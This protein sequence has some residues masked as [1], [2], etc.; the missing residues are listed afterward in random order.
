MRHRRGRRRRGGGRRFHRGR[1]RRRP[2]RAGTD[3]DPATLSA[4]PAQMLPAALPRRRADVDARS[5][6]GWRCR[7]GVASVGRRSSTRGPA[8]GLR[9]PYSSV[10][11]ASYGLEGFGKRRTRYGRTSSAWSSA[12][13]VAEVAPPELAGENAA[14]ARRG[15]ERLGWSHGYLRRNAKGCVG[16]GVCAFGCP[17]GAKQHAGITYVPRAA[18][19]RRGRC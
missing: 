10:G 13:S 19:G 15:A 8:S 1:P 17:T 6:A 5:P 12:L 16:S 18:S 4:R 7:W 14:V 2:A 3:H 11:S 9:P